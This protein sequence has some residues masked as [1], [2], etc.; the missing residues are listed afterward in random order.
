M[1]KKFNTERFKNIFIQIHQLKIKQV[2]LT[3]RSTTLE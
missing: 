2:G 3:G 1:S